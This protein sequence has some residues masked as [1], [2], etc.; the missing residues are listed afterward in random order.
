[1][2]IIGEYM[3]QARREWIDTERKKDP[4]FAPDIESWKELL[5]LD[6][7]KEVE[8]FENLLWKSVALNREEGYKPY[9]MKKSEKKR[10]IHLYN[11]LGNKYF[12]LDISP[13]L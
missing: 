9:K 1:M 2:V 5:S 3:E 7:L 4:N 11:K 13:N 8:E 6:Q 12:N 10:F